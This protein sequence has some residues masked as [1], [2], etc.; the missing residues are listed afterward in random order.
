M[1]LCG[2]YNPQSLVS[3]SFIPW[4]LSTNLPIQRYILWVNARRYN[5]AVCPDV[6]DARNMRQLRLSQRWILIMP[7]RRTG[8]IPFLEVE[9]MSN[10]FP[11]HA[12]VDIC[13]NNDVQ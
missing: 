4:C 9:N 10:R 11:Q 12:Q 7:I 3:H 13:Y 6:M 8:W 1:T 5:H 2:N